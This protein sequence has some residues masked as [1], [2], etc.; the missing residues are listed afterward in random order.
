MRIRRI[1]LKIILGEA[2]SSMEKQ[3][4]MAAA[5]KAGKNS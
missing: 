5:V 3:S 1:G 4:T 2:R